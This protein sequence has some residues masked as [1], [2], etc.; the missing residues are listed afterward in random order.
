MKRIFKTTTLL[1][2]VVAVVFALQSCSSVKPID[3]SQLAGNWVL[4]TMQGEDAKA[5]F[6]GNLPNIQFDFSK[7]TIH[8]VGGCNGYNGPFTLNEK[9]EFS[10]GNVA[11]T[12]KMC[13]HANKEPQYF[14]ALSTPNMVVSLENGLLTFKQDKTVVLQFEKGEAQTQAPV[15]TVTAENLT[16]KW[17]LTAMGTEDLSALF[18]EKKPTMEIS[19]DGKV[20]GN[21]GCNNYRSSYTLEGDMVTF[22]PAMSTKM[23]CPSLK[24]EQQ[25]TSALGSPMQVAM[26]G[27]KLIFSKDGNMVFELTKAE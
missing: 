3:K 18:T 9:N 13:I 22:G 25:F 24:G 17:N 16:G 10:A 1:A 21:A 20:V 26:D 19:A 12:M 14:T 27:N 11:A 4:K 15:Q 6:E 5:V 23:A 8:G 2:A 7:N